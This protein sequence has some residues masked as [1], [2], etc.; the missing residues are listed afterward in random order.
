MALASL[1]SFK[2]K[3]KSKTIDIAFAMLMLFDKQKLQ[4]D[5]R[6]HSLN[7]LSND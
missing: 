1:V 2:S 4:C 6:R 5:A 3:I 7:T